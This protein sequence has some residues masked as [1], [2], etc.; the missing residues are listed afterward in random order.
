LHKAQIFGILL[1][2]VGVSRSANWPVKLT[3]HKPAASLWV[4]APQFTFT[5]AKIHYAK[6]ESVANNTN[7]IFRSIMNQGKEKERIGK[8]NNKTTN[9]KKIPK[10]GT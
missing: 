10:F 7:P 9:N 6:S 2:P 3:S 5:L 1:L 4:C 8:F